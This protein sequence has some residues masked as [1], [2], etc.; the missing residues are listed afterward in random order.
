[1]TVEDYDRELARVIDHTLLRTDAEKADFDRVCEEAIR[2][3]F[4]SVCVFS[5]DVEYVAEKLKG[6][7]VIP[8]AVVGFPHGQMTP[9]AKAFEA[10]DAITNRGA[11]EIDMVIHVSA[12]K[13]KHYILVLDDIQQVVKA[14]GDKP[15]KV[16]IETGLLTDT[17][18]IAACTLAKTAGARF[19]KTST[20]KEEGGATVDDVRLMR[21]V[22]GDEVLIKASGGV[23][24]REF[25]YELIEAGADRIGTS[26]GIAIVTGKAA[27]GGY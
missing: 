13:S 21:E 10:H 25:A 27:E 24:S 26:N 19:I 18:K 20:G 23:N 6:S 16:I 9:V 8:I 11:E 5:G 2:Y 17:E 22:V 14:C 1:M 7:D 15:V 4:R 12:I 3:H